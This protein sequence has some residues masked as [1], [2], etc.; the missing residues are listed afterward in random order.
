MPKATA[1]LSSSAR[2]SI[3]RRKKPTDENKLPGAQGSPVTSVQEGKTRSRKK[4]TVL[5]QQLQAPMTSF[6]PRPVDPN[7]GKHAELMKK[8][9]NLLACQVDAFQAKVE[10]LVHDFQDLRDALEVGEQ[11][12]E[13]L[14]SDYNMALDVIREEKDTSRKQ[15]VSLKNAELTIERLTSALPS[16]YDGS[17]FFACSQAIC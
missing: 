2:T 6:A 14:E 12:F 5:N 9:L 4:I 3:K 7:M 1:S 16:D 15:Y 8:G 17:A 11:Q 10:A 13:A